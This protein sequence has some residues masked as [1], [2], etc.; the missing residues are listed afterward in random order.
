VRS[1]NLRSVIWEK[2]LGQCTTC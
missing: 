1:F 2:T